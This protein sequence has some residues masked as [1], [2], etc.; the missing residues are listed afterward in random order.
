[1]GDHNLVPVTLQRHNSKKELKK[2][3]D[4]YLH[5]K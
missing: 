1:M 5:I 4:V 2:K 3:K